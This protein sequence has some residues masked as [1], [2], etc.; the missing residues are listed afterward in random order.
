MRA[1]DHRSTKPR[2]GP[3]LLILLAATHFA[4][5]PTADWM[6]VPRMT[7]ALILSIV[8]GILY[9]L[10]AGLLRERGD[11]RAASTVAVG[12]DLGVLAAGLFLGY[13]W[14]VHLRPGAVA[15]LALQLAVAF[16]EIV[17]R[18][19]ARHPLT[20]ATRLAW[21]V[22]LYSLVFA[23]YVAFKPGAVADLPG[24]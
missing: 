21:F 15:V 8:L 10:A 11:L 22:V 12:E 20:P 9:A 6:G 18:Q 4:Y 17:R 7:S 1:R 14:G 16:A 5:L 2:A 13:P 19:E 23:A 24:V 3:I